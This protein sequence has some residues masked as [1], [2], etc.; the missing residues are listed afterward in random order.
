MEIVLVTSLLATILG[1]VRYVVVHVFGEALTVWSIGRALTALGVPER[2]VH[3]VVLGRA[4][5]PDDRLDPPPPPAR[6]V[7]APLDLLA[8]RLTRDKPA[9]PPADDPP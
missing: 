5:G 9:G 1:V 4:R 7:A 6:G 8:R 3:A 2:E